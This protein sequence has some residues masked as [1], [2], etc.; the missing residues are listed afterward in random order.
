[1]EATAPPPSSADQRGAVGTVTPRRGHGPRRTAARQPHPGQAR[2]HSG[3]PRGRA[4][5][6]AG[7]E[8][9]RE[10]RMANG[11]SEPGADIPAGGFVQLLTPEGERVDSVTTTDGVTY[12]VNFADDEYRELYR[13]LVT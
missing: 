4:T 5:P 1:M 8:R 10:T 13:D 7:A 2:R 11:E 3:S 12:S 9:N 6:A